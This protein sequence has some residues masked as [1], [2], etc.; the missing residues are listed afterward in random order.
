M[1]FFVALLLRMTYR[2]IL[3]RLAAQNDKYVI[4]RRSRRIPLLESNYEFAS[5]NA[6]MNATSFSTPSMGIA[7]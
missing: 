3:R 4:L 2:R 1:G 6:F 7:L 5:S